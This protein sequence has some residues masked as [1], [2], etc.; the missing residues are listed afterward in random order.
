MKRTFLNKFNHEKARVFSKYLKNNGKL[1]TLNAETIPTL[2]GNIIE[3]SLFPSE[4]QVYV[5][6]KDK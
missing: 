1:S 5:V 3:A 6:N 4:L 2:N